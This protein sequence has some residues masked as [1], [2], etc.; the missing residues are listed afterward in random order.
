MGEARHNFTG[1]PRTRGRARIET[2]QHSTTTPQAHPLEPQWDTGYG[3]CCL[4]HHESGSYY[5]SHGYP[6]PS[7]QAGTSASVRYPDWYAPLDRYASYGVDQA[8]NAVEGIG[9]LV[10][11]MDDFTHAQTKM[12][13]SIDSQTSTMHDLYGHFRINPDA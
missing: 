12:Q 2:A 7:L 3:G 9:R 13:A 8:D 5:P 6:E 1:P 10:H 11:Q 4:S